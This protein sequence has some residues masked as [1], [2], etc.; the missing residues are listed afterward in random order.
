MIQYIKEIIKKYNLEEFIRFV[1]VGILATL[2]SYTIYYL[3]IKIIDKN[4]AYT[5]G[6]IISFCFN[7]LAS[8]LFTFKTKANIKN[9]L[10]FLLAHLTNFLIQIILLNIFTCLGIPKEYAP[11]P[12]YIIAIPV[13]FVV[14]RYALKGKKPQNVV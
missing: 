6:Y 1:I 12:V 8:N 10:R 4:I 5:I 7:F 14:V 13:N 11:I 3:F 2:I 9:G